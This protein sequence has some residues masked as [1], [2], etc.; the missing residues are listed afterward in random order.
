MASPTAVRED[1]CQDQPH[2]RAAPTAPGR[3]ITSAA[4]ARSGHTR[5]SVWSAL[6]AAAAG[7][8]CGAVCPAAG[9]RVPTTPPTS[10]PSP[11]TKRPTIPS[12]SRWSLVLANAGVMSISAPS[13]SVSIVGP[14]TADSGGITIGPMGDVSRL[15]PALR[16]RVK[17]AV[18]CSSS[19]HTRGL[20][21]SGSRAG[22]PRGVR[23]SRLW[24]PTA[25][26]LPGGGPAVGP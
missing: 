5:P 23:R 25:I 19:T 26:G 15:V 16:W 9:W 14:H 1:R 17:A 10:T 20:V 22:V 4:P 6:S 2:L 11:T 12:P 24:Q 21:P 3:A 18:R 8:G 7:W 13:D